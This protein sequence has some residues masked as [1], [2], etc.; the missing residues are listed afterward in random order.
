MDTSQQ[1]TALNVSNSEDEGKKAYGSGLTLMPS[2]FH[3]NFCWFRVGEF[4]KSYFIADLN[5]LKR[6]SHPYFIGVNINL[7]NKM[8]LKIKCKIK[9]LL[10]QY[11]Q[12]LHQRKHTLHKINKSILGVSE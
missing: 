6:L 10:P 7:F 1:D 12:I 2:E 9:Q 8:K 3:L 11:F 5:K 4:K